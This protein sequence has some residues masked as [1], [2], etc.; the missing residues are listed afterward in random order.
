MTIREALLLMVL[1]SASTV[2]GEEVRTPVKNLLERKDHRLHVDPSPLE[3]A[4]RRSA[5]MA[6]G[7]DQRD[8]VLLLVRAEFPDVLHDRSEQVG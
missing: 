2:R 5:P 8:V 6:A 1:W 3:S 7:D 4:A